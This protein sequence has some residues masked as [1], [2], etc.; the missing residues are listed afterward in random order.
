MDISSGVRTK[1]YLFRSFQIYCLGAPLMVFRSSKH[2]PTF[3]LF[4]CMRRFF[5][6]F[7]FAFFFPLP[8]YIFL[9]IPLLSLQLFSVS[10]QNLNCDSITL[11]FLKKDAMFQRHYCQAPDMNA[12]FKYFRLYCLAFSSPLLNNQLAPSMKKSGNQSLDNLVSSKPF[13]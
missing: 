3:P 12:T 5:R 11:L 1:V 8:L 9:F 13:C 2:R 7:H 10:N 6:S 4:S